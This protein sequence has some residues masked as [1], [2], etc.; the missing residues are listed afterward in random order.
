M[1][2][3]VVVA[4]CVLLNGQLFAAE[5]PNIILF[6]TDDQSPFTWD[7]VGWESAKAFG[8]NGESSVHTPEIDRI[9]REGMIFDRAYVSSSVCSPSRYSALSGR[10]AGRSTG[11][12]FLQEHPKGRMTRVENNTELEY[13]RPNVATVLQANGYRT[14]FVGKSHLIEHK[15]AR[16][17]KGSMDALKV[18]D[19]RGD[20]RAPEVADA[21]RHNFNH[22]KEKVA[23]Q[24]FD[25]VDGVYVA[26]L[27]E[28][29]NEELNVHNVEWTTRAAL[30]FVKSSDDTPF[31]LYYAT[32]VP[33]GP[34]PW[35]E[36][37]YPIT[38]RV[39]SI[40]RRISWYALQLDNL[41]REI[42]V[43][44]EKGGGRI[45]ELG[46]SQQWA[47]LVQY[48]RSV[49][50]PKLRRD[51]YYPFG[52]HADP[53]M[54]GEGYADY[55]YSFAPSREDILIEAIKNGADPR[56]AWL[57]WIDY[58]I[59]ALRKELVEQG[60]WDNTL[61]IVTSD[62]GA[63]RHGKTTL[64]EA[65]VRVPLAMRWPQKIKGGSRYGDLVQNIDFAPTI[66]EAAGIS[67]PAE[68]EADGVSMMEVLEGSEEPIHDYLFAELGF[69][70]AVLTK[71]WKYI[72]V[73]HSKVVRKQIRAGKKFSGYEGRMLD[74]PYLTRNRH[75]GYFASLHN[76]HYYE[77]DQL[78]NII[79]D[80]KEEQN[81]VSQQP[82]RVKQMQGLLS[83]T[84][85]SF[86]DRP[87][88]EFT[89]N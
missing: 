58:S 42:D 24:G 20:P 33:H 89:K 29:N 18:Y 78:F 82:E 79:D 86:P 45:S 8:F 43:V 12:F 5:R 81:I 46:L 30:N 19:E 80:P 1:K 65:G 62:H 22:W 40:K 15:A 73:R 7:Y 69:S 70:R 57:T 28:L 34:S 76:E 75:L 50:L 6:M 38:G 16:Q 48:W 63:W 47:D 67:T 23:S 9:A 53:K 56:D 37:P 41:V 25:Y 14:G 13:D 26:N 54:T 52:L 36:R 32:T 68:M 83:D 51:Q 88:G 84:L 72:A 31:F 4:L 77:A 2:Y 21:L 61:I 74:Q 66:L 49:L 44:E 55:D 27:Q 60:K 85:R 35:I 87:F 64:Y 59:G 71:D 3:V 17:W 39:D 11:E 10:Y